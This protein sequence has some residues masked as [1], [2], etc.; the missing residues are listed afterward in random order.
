MNIIGPDALVFGVDDIAACAQYLTDYGLTPVG[1]TAQGGRFEA[2][3]GTAVEIRAQDDPALPPSLGTASLLRETVYGVAD[4]ATLDAI[5]AELTR[6]RVVVRQGDVLRTT[7]DLGFALAFQVTVRKP[8]SMPAESVNAPGDAP[9]RAPNAL[10]L[11]PD[12]VARPARCRMSCTS[13][14]TRP[15]PRRFMPAW[16]LSAQTGSQASAPSCALRAR[17]TTTRCS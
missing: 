9:Q 13:F 4:A 8:L 15:R 7:D 11:P 12:L 5:E 3:D 10:G 1:V 17:K 14:R 6:D 2:L 16:V